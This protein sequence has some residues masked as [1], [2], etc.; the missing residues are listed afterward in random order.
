MG[1]FKFLI[2]IF[3]ERVLKADYL[4]L[5]VVEALSLQKLGEDGGHL[6]EEVAFVFEERCK[7]LPEQREVKEGQID[8]ID[9]LPA[10][11]AQLVWF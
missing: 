2:E 1:F 9:V 10:H 5:S 6:L 8:L 7:L 11:L 4:I 3:D